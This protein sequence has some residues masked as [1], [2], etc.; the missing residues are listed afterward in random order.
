MKVK[1]MYNILKVKKLPRLLGSVTPSFCLDDCLAT[2]AATVDVEY[3]F[4]YMDALRTV[5]SSNKSKAVG[6]GKSIDFNILVE[7]NLANYVGIKREKL[8]MDANEGLKQ[9]QQEFDRNV[10]FQFTI[11][12]FECPWD[13]RYQVIEAGAHS[14][15]VS[16]WDEERQELECVDPYYDRQQVFL[17]YENYVKGFQYLTKITYEP[18]EKY[19]PEQVLKEKLQHLLEG[20]QIATLKEMAEDI[21]V[22]FNLELEIDQYD[23]NEFFDMNEIQ[24]RIHINSAMKELSHNRV[25][26]AVML[27]K[28]ARKD[29]DK[30]ESL[31]KLA[32]DALYLAEKWDSV[33][34]MLI[35][36]VFAR[37]TSNIAEYL[38]KKMKDV[39]EQEEAYIQKVIRV[40]EGKKNKLKESEVSTKGEDK[41]EIHF[42]NLKA[43]FNN[44]GIGQYGSKT[45]DFN[46]SGEYFINDK[47]PS[48][49]KV[50]CK[51]TEFSLAQKQEG[52]ADNIACSKQVISI[53]PGYYTK[54]SFLGCSEWGNYKEDVGITYEDGTRESYRIELSDWMPNLEFGQPQNIAFTSE[55]AVVLMNGKLVDTEECNIYIAQIHT[56][57]NKR[58]ANIT[59]P[60][61][62][63]MHIF[64]ITL[65]ERG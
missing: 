42:A 21:N 7:E 18:C 47:F 5:Y 34:M 11:L 57:V 27:K 26:F 45:A 50:F 39:V 32:D 40:L 65:K 46:N 60:E 17:P 33:R 28:L 14:L 44:E 61:C 30:R 13:W 35:K 53:E 64:A 52:K 63:N 1:E 38:S 48:G 19:N 55:K 58:I 15:Y 29:S 41:G 16:R 36:K 20:G 37:K 59:L 49:N 25:R 8:S 4:A 62:I 22:D 31:E 51:D 54:I 12:G 43:F 56:K 9:I 23:E 2:Y 6:I 3:E 24:N 10:A